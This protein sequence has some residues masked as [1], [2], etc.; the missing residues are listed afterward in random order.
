MGGMVPLDFRFP[1]PLEAKSSLRAP[2]IDPPRARG[3]IFDHKKRL[4][5]AAAAVGAGRA[6]V[7]FLV[8]ESM[9]R[10]RGL[11]HVHELSSSLIRILDLSFDGGRIRIGLLG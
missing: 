3:R 2:K 7:F 5:V 4:V 1:D 10:A 6:S 9:V 11:A 8:G